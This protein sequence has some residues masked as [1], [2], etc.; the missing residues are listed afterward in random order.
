LEDRMLNKALE[1]RIAE[2]ED[3]DDDDGDIPARFTPLK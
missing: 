1:N 2:L 3:E